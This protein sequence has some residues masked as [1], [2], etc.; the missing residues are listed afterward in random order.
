MK[1]IA[2][3]AVALALVAGFTAAAVAADETRQRHADVRQVLAQEGRRRTSART[4]S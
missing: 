3:L 2:K 1:T 4:C